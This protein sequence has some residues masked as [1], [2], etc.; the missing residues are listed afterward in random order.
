[1][2]LN[3]LDDSEQGAGWILAVVFTPICI[4]AT[5]L[6]FVATKCGGR[7]I[8]WE[9]WHA[10]LALV[11]F[12]PYVGYML[13]T[14]SIINGTPLL[15]WAKAHRAEY[16]EVAKVGVNMNGLYGIQ[17][18]FAKFSLLALYHRLFWVDINF[19]RA[20]WATAIVQG[21]WGIVVL[22]V[23]IFACV[24]VAKSW[25][26]ELDGF[27]VNINLFF[28]IY[29]PVN[30]AIDF[31]M[32]GMAIYMLHALQMKKRAQWHLS[33]LFLIG[34]FSGVIGI[35]K[36]VQA[37][38]S[39][40]RNFLSIIW[41]LVQMATS[42]ICCCA[43]IYQSILPK[44]GLYDALRSWASRSFAS[45]RPSAVSND[46]FSNATKSTKPPSSKSYQSET[47]ALD[48]HAHWTHL[49]G[50]SERGLAWAEIE[51]EHGLGS[52]DKEMDGDRIPMKT[53]RV[54]H[55]VDIV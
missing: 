11:F 33:A 21:A 6:R 41:N 17:Q 47:R 7:K 24:P 5:V 19:N 28:S 50:S 54:E 48:R 45:K 9:D 30:S 20:V 43:P 4:L 22:L 3:V 32:A 39:A 23:H 1:M 29:E 53:V 16:A 52:E 46:H 37:Q 26:P 34:G 35:I 36:T 2:A 55:S 27:C 18:S 13:W 42:I 14:F 31:W 15:V 8:G 44:V 40:Q 49:D 38:N 25:Q 10:L 12:L 51:A